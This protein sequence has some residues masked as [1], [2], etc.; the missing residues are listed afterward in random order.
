MVLTNIMVR[1]LFIQTLLL[2]VIMIRKG[3]GNLLSKSF[4]KREIP[5]SLIL[6]N[7]DTL[8]RGCQPMTIKNKVKIPMN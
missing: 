1:Y 5:L 6:W 3:Q 8:V 2:E 4:K 7:K